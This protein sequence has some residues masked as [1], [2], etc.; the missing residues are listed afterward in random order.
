MLQDEELTSLKLTMLDCMAEAAACGHD[1]TP[2]EPVEGTNHRGYQAVCRK[3]GVKAY[4]GPGK[5]MSL[6]AD[7]CPKA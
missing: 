1:L 3:C 4:T 2:W 5:I 6:L 7:R